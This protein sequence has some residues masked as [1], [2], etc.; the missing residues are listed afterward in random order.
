MQLD[1]PYLIHTDNN[2]FC[3]MNKDIKMDAPQILTLEDNETLV[4]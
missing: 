4:L 1:Q 2:C 3:S